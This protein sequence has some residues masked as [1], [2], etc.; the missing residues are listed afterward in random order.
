M[1]PG[2]KRARLVALLASMLAASSCGDLLGLDGPATARPG[3]GKG[4]ALGGAPDGALGSGAGGSLG[5][6]TGGA[7]GGGN[8]GGTGGT[9]DP[10]ASVAPDGESG[11][12]DAEVADATGESA[13]RDDAGPL[14]K[15]DVQSPLHCAAPIACTKLN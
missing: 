11:S 2:G 13:D 3:G 5:S 12:G 6:A 7:A 10:D 1:D 14:C 15:A 8:E 9:T 4:G